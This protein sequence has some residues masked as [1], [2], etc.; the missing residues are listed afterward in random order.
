MTDRHHL[1]VHGGTFAS[2]GD[3][4]D[5]S[6]VRGSGAPDGLFVRDARHLSRWQLTVDGAVPETLAPVSDGDTARCV[7]VPRGG[8][9]EPPA[10]TLFREQAVAEGGL[11]ETLRVTGNR[12]TPTTVRIALTVDV[13]FTDQFELRS[14][15]R[16]YVKSGTVRTRQVLDDGVEFR[17]RRGEWTSSTTVTAEPAPD[18][19]E[20][21]G[22][23]ARR[24][25]WT[26]ELQPHG[27]AEVT[28][29]V[30][31]R[32]HGTP[33]PRMPRS[34]ADV[35]ERIQAREGEFAEGV[36]FPTGW[37]EL[38]AV[39]ARGLADLAVLQVPATGPDGEDLRV[40]AAGVPWFLALLGRDALLASLFMLP[41]RPRSAAATIL[42]LA[43][44]Q[45]GAPGAT[46]RG[47]VAQPG[48]IVHEVR[49]GELAH[50]GQVPYGRYYGS[51][52]STP[53]FLVL[54]GAYTEQTGDTGLARRLESHARAAVEWMLDHGGLTSRGY[55]VYRADEGGLANQ[56]WKDSPGAICASDG[57]RAG[58]AVLAAGAQG[59]AY[60][61]LRR[62]ATVART[63][64]GDDVYAQLLE[65]A[66]A[67][68]RDRFQRDFWMADREFPALAL[69]GEGNRLDALASDAGH[70]LWSGLLDKEYG[71]AV[72]RRLL[73]PDFFSGWGVRTL[74]SGQ[75]AYHPLSYHRGSVWPHD[76]ALIALGLA[77]YGLHDEARTV[78]HALVDAATASGHRLPEVLAGYGRDT[79]REPVPYPHACVR[80]SRAA[81]TPLALLTAVGGA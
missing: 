11:V 42:A 29:R 62:T 78:A 16:T 40:P 6:G 79:R 30:A 1:L 61:A 24:L 69:D 7:L 39:C 63:V 50:F 54:L 18:N 75:S 13:D 27:S 19:V 70:L 31:A 66:A 4:G 12:P 60:D 5:I 33:Q 20:E 77:R 71:E 80:G 25:V 9:Q 28:L 55:L 17:Y 47:M 67:D 34:P 41:Y 43:A 74:A 76:N 57:T 58:G 35:M 22:T 45:A 64:W 10:Y 38:A 56:N 36:A 53:L 3:S 52:D 26:L 15:H 32:P 37:R 21:T 81:A 46:G 44:T 23:G 68:L 73:E 51:V 14:D 49:H 65:Q 72:G 2:V 48:K 59:Y 8:R